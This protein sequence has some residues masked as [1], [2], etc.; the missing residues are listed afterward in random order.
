MDK[1]AMR[2][3]FEAVD[4]EIWCIDAGLYARHYRE[5]GHYDD[6]PVETRWRTWQAAIAHSCEALRNE[7]HRDIMNL[8]LKPGWHA[9]FDSFE[10]LAYKT[11]H[12]D[13]RHAAAELALSALSR[14]GE[15][16]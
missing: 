11:G 12:R 4:G 6:W 13:A 14:Q 15:G 9:G 16:A 10:E 3:A 5:D 1:E 2:K 8:P 7:L